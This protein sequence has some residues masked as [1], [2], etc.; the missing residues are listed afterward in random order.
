LQT[1]KGSI[2]VGVDADFVIWNPDQKFTVDAKA[3]HHRHKLTPYDGEV[4]GGVVQKTFLRGRKIYD[5]GH[6]DVPLG[7]MLLKV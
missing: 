6:F 5:G 2:A 4:L 3:L 1:Q 7:H